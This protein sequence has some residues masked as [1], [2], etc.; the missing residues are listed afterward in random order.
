M[1]TL[2][3]AGPTGPV[4]EAVRRWD[5]ETRPMSVLVSFAYLKEWARVRPYFRAPKSLMLDSGAY[6]AYQ[7]GRA[8]DHDALLA[9]MARPEWTEA[10]G[11]DVIG[12]WQGSKRNAEYALARGAQKGM[13]VFHIGDPWDLLA[14][15]CDRFP[16]VGLSCRFGEPIGDSIRFYGQCFARHWPHRFHSFGWIDEKALFTYPF[17]SADAAT[18][19]LAATKF[20]N[21]ATKKRGVAVQQHVSVEGHENRAHLLT[22]HMESMWSREQS[23]Q[24]RWCGELARIPTWSPKETP[25]ATQDDPQAPRPTVA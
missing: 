7:L 6:T 4:I 25:D 11:L 14:W 13:P 8:I 17:H 3:L 22:G 20:K 16:K 21:M 23:L 19:V 15:Y 5:W 24:Q 2:Y 18:W 12:D 1:T 10:V 9:E